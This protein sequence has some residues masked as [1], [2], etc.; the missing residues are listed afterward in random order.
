MSELSTNVEITVAEFKKLN[1]E[2]APKMTVAANDFIPGVSTIW[3]SKIGKREKSKAV[4]EANKGNNAFNKD[5]MHIQFSN[6][7][8][9]LFSASSFELNYSIK[10]ETDEGQKSFA[11]RFIKKGLTTDAERDESTAMLDVE[12][13]LLK[14]K[15]AENQLTDKGNPMIPYGKI[16]GE[17]REKLSAGDITYQEAV[18]AIFGMAEGTLSGNNEEKAAAQHIIDACNDKYVQNLLFTVE[19]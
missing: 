11:D 15:S 18:D 4:I 10:I 17:Y 2:S 16:T 5:F 3:I 6:P 8:G 1:V 19:E 12:T 7:D 14:F 13:K 9:D